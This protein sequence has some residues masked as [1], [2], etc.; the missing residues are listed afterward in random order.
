MWENPLSLWIKDT[1]YPGGEAG[2][3][4]RSAGRYKPS[5]IVTG[6]IVFLIHVSK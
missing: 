2:I 3:Q 4:K 5:Q 6:N 1:L